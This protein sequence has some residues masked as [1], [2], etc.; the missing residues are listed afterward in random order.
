[1]QFR[2]TIFERVLGCGTLIIESASD[3]PLEFEDIP[4]VERVHALLYHEVAEER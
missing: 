4:S 3:E 1:M 2:H